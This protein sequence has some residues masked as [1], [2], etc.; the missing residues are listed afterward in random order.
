[1]VLWNSDRPDIR[2]AIRDLLGA[3]L[4]ERHGELSYRA[5]ADVSEL[6]EFRSALLEAAE[7]DEHELARER[8][9]TAA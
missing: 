6:A 3:D 5:M 2:L 7:H 4:W 9:E 8:G 1:M